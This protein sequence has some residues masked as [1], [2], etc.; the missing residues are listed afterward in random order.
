MGYFYKVLEAK[1]NRKVVI[2]W[3]CLN[4]ENSVLQILSPLNKWNS[5]CFNFYICFDLLN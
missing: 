5:I 2:E 4:L 3:I 1:T